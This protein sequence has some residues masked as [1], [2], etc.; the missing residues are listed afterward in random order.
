MVRHGETAWNKENKLCGWF[1]AP[2]SKKGIQ[3]ALAADQTLKRK[4]YQFDT[5]HTSVLT[6]VQHTLKVILEEIE[7][8]SLPV[9]K[10]LRLRG[11]VKHLDKLSDEATMGIN[12]PNR[13]TFVYELDDNLKPIKCMQF[14]GD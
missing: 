13:I 12:L 9:E 2:S 7:Q 4:G 3:E 5:A 11:I 8:S 10:T 6:R 1:N 14:L